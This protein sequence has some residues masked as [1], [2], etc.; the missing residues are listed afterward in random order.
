MSETVLID[1][2]PALK[3]FVDMLAGTSSDRRILRIMGAEK[4]GKSRLLREFRKSS[5]ELY[6]AHCALVDLRSKFQSYEDVL[7]QIVQQVTSIEFKSFTD[8]QNQMSS[9]TPKV[10]I[11]GLRL[12]LS[13]MTVNLHGESNSSTEIQN[14]QRLTSS[15]C[16]DILSAGLRT[17]LVIQFDTFDSASPK[18]QDWLNDQLISSL[19]QIPNL[20]IIIAGRTLLDVPSGWVDVCDSY[21][22]PPASLEDHK[23]YCKSLGIDTSE[24]VIKALHEVFEGIP[25][26]FAE[27]ASK[28]KKEMNS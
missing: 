10:E 3:K 4:M 28:L 26:L 13:A 22:L 12:L 6:N 25:G 5:Y 9:P 23:N 21:F 19:L 7:Y 27:Y 15:F 14:R 11:S 17:P 1:R 8:L 20:Y 2:V 24:E 18:I 16:R